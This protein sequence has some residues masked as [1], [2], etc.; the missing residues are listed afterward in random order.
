MFGSGVTG[1]FEG[2]FDN[3]D[4]SHSILLGYLNRNRAQDIDIPIGPN[5]HIDPGGP[6]MGQPTH[7]LAG[8]RSGMFIVTVPKAFT[9]EQHLTWTIT[10][11]GQTN[12]IPL[13]LHPDYVITPLFE[14]AHANTPPTLH[15]VDADAPGIQGPMAQMSKAI[16]RTA[17]VSTPLALPFTVEDDAK[18]CRSCPVVTPTS[19]PRP[20]VGVLWSKYRGPGEVT[21]EKAAPEL[22]VLKG[23]SVDQPYAGKATVTAT[24]KEAGDYVLHVL[25]TDYS[26]PTGGGTMCCWTT[27]M[28]KVSVTR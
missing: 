16:S 19:R 26:G 14:V 27:A 1:G 28:V 10:A 13:R 12:I 24:F 5:N 17:S 9:A 11:N 4:G 18:L 7:F 6:D 2:W 21:F 3:P 23:G 8:R 25:A 22:Q 20:P 15:L